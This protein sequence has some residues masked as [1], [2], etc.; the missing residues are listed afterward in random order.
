M[1]KLAVQR[2][3]EAA[4]QPKQYRSREP[5]IPLN[6]GRLHN[7]PTLST[8]LP[9]LASAPLLLQRTCA[10]GGSC[11]RCQS[12]QMRSVQ[13]QPHEPGDQDRQSVN[14]LAEQMFGIPEVTPEAS[15]S[16]F[17][18]YPSQPVVHYQRADED[19]AALESEN[20]QPS[21]TV[22]STEEMQALG[23]EAGGAP[24]DAGTPAQAT[25][26]CPTSVTLGQVS[27]FNHSSLSAADKLAFR[28]YLGAVS[29]MDVGPGPD[30]SGHCM[31]EQLTTVSNNCP[32]AVYSRGGTTS[33]PCTGNR[34]LDINRWGSA[35]DARTHTTLSD[36]PTSFIDLHRTLNSA[37]LLE[38]TGVSSCSVVCE[39]IYKCDR[40]GATTGRFQITRN[41]Q[42]GTLATGD[43][44]TLHITTGTVTKT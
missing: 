31:K 8:P 33:S 43:G 42:A 40:T 2:S 36:G 18:S 11:P 29:R 35:G 41:Y 7:A 27:Q 34:C 10:C 22:G 20:L 39:Q 16:G 17:S 28:T 19:G 5:V 13:P 30:H 9:L 24:S 12:K 6:R 23:S 4:T 25:T 32:A 21:E 26:P 44:G 1:R 14:R 38:G 15:T 3:V 37:S